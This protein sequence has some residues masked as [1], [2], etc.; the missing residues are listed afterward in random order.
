[1]KRKEK[2]QNELKW[3]KMKR[4]TIVNCDIKR[5]KQYRKKDRKGK[6]NNGD[7]SKKSL[8]N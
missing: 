4:K 6:E 8:T 5:I 1:M 2:E 3:T 7:E